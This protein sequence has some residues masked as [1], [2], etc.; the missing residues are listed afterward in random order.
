MLRQTGLEMFMQGDGGS[1][2]FNFESPKERD[3]VG[4][5]EEA[6]VEPNRRTNSAYRSLQ[7]RARYTR[8]T[9]WGA[10]I[11]PSSSA[12]E[13]EQNACSARYAAR[14]AKKAVVLIFLYRLVF[15]FVCFV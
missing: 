15:F 2:F 11:C 6:C 14:E 8:D 12:G 7:L 4:A 10:F 13:A 9:K 1:A 5:R 3:E